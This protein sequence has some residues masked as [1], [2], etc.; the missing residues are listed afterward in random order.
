[1]YKK[2]LNTAVIAHVD[3]GKTTLTNNLLRQSNVLDDLGMDRNPLEQKRG[4]TM[5]SKVASIYYKET[6]INLIDT[7][8]HSDFG[9]EV[10]RI[11]SMA[12]SVLLLVDSAEGVMP[13]TKFVLSKALKSGLRPIVIVNKVDRP[14]RRLEE[15]VNEI[16]DLFLSLDANDEQLDFPV[17]YAS[18]RD[19]WCIRDLNDPKDNLIPLLETIMEYTP[20]REYDYKAPFS[21]LVTMLENDNFVG[22]IL[23]GKIEKGSIAANASVKA[24][25]LKGELVENARLT[26]LQIFEGMGK[27]NADSAQAG[28][29]IAIAGVSEA[30]VTDTICD[31]SVTDPIAAIPIDPT[32]ISINVS[33][34]TSPL[35][36]RDGDKLT[37]RVILD[38]LLQEV[39]TNVSINLE[40]KGEGQ[41]EVRGRGE[42]QLGVLIENMR[43]EGFELS[44]S[45]PRVVIRLD[46][47][48]QK[49]E[50][51]EE[52]TVDL[53]E[54]Y[55]GIVMET[56]N[57]RKGIMQS[58]DNYPGG[59][60]RL[61]YHIP[62]RSL[63]G[64]HGQFLSDT[65]GTGI[66]NKVFHG[67]AP[68]SGKIE[69]RSSGVL[70]SNGQGEAV[71]YAL[72]NLQDRGIMFVKPQDPVY[73]GMI[74]GEHNRSNDL[75]VNV[76]KG[77]QLTN[78]RAAGSDEAVRLSPPRIM[79]LE[80]MMS[81][82][83]D[84][85]LVE[86]TPSSLRLRKKEL[87]PNV[88]KRM[89]RN[90]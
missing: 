86:V 11:M 12:D 41:Y 49:L 48:G 28:E 82:I 66:L 54:E 1:M 44:V 24:I 33:V 85:E 56:L 23:I 84:D 40:E 34:N 51:I 32:T 53:D 50:P 74:V 30:S 79:T 78:I 42:L 88:R 14:D 63:I 25:N 73:C 17:L 70:I 27:R 71:A 6:K 35:T 26:K 39:K 5:F 4:I 68:Y 87:D 8:G 89:K 37:S 76:L 77:K 10:E 21:M 31:P 67:Y 36:G 45:R 83:N 16:S 57:T 29:I 7:P 52:L 20:V 65:R 38:R 69:S 43:K 9:G 72:F 19:G 64:Y 15:V 47:N 62:S 81:Y 2:V 61:V 13:Q 3:H 58:M 80:E 55:A 90:D 75:E 60:V 22:R 18:G 46:E 59:R